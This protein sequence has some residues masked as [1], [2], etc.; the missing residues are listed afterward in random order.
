MK[1]HVVPIKTAGIATK[2]MVMVKIERLAKLATLRLLDI[3][4]ILILF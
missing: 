4:P 2:S 3:N 1:Q